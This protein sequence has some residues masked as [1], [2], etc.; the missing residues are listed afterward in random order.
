VSALEI[1]GGVEC[2]I[3][4]IGDGTRNQL[5]ETGH[6]D[7]PT[8]LDLIAGLGL[9]TI[10][11]PVLWEM[12]ET[13]PGRRDWS[14]PDSRLPRLRE[15]GIDP[16]AG[17]L[18]HGSGPAWADW[19][20]PDFPD[21]FADYAALVARRYPWI[22]L[23]TPINEPF[24][25]ARISGMYAQWQ[26]HGSDEPTCLRL[27]VRQCLAITR[28][29]AAIRRV[30]PAARLVQTEDFGRV[31][32]TPL[33]S[34]Q[35]DYENERRWLATD[36]LCGRVTPGHLFWDRLLGAGV[37]EAA[38]TELAHASC[39]PDMIG[40]DY[41]LTSDRF[42]DEAAELYPGEQ[43]GGNGRERYVDIAAARSA[44][45]LG[46]FGLYWRLQEVWH[47]YGL[48]IAVTE[49][50]N[51]S[52]RD[53]QLRWLAEGWRAAQAARAAGVDV[54]AVAAWSL[55]GAVDSNSML[56][57]QDGYYE[58]GAFDTR[59]P[60]P[61]KTVVADAIRSLSTGVPFDHPVLDRPGWWGADHPDPAHARPLL[62]SGFGHL[63]STLEECCSRRRLR[64][65][66]AESNADAQF[67]L[68]KHRAWALIT[69]N[70]SQP[71][72]RSPWLHLTSQFASGGRLSMQAPA[73][74]DWHNI[75]NAFLDL[76]VDG[77]QGSVRL[78]QA[79]HA[80]QYEM[81][82]LVGD[83]HFEMRAAG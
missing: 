16:I 37:D 36:L 32:A 43:V 78:T 3:V 7:R 38:L 4:R 54:R 46:N 63:A 72:Q 65:V 74:F 27:T 57:R 62:L 14:W 76:L 2:S 5:A 45:P 18:H 21:L 19:L 71:G 75:T 31:F 30:T 83:E 55:F 29:M 61:R 20:H 69:I 15:L 8:D 82:D 68:N 42:L 40:I 51:G 13:A 80:N 28:A 12:V 11:Y 50:H 53:E 66:A 77:R 48:P 41:Y 23:F 58:P 44:V 39:A 22:E 73:S 1:W 67:L 81:V 47:R 34:A 26:P 9:R 79:D 25:T 60:A 56:V 33:L 59:F 17:L 64:V 70:P 52:T 24:T 49:L 10:R 35:A 6:L